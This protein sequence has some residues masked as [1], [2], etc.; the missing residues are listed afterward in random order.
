[1]P[2]TCISFLSSLL[3]YREGEMHNFDR[4]VCLTLVGFIFKTFWVVVAV[5]TPT[6][7]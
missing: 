3:I 4:V 2:V 7:I 6:D 5:L 1:M